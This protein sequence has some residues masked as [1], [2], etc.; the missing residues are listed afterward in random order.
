R[1]L[2]VLADGVEFV[3]AWYGALKAGG[4]TAEAYTFLPVKDLAYLLRYSQARLVVADAATLP[5]VREAVAASP[6]Q[7]TVIAVGV[8]TAELGVGELAWEASL[9]E[10]PE[11][12]PPVPTR[13][14]E[15]AIWKFTTG[16]T[17]S[18]KAAVHTHAAPRL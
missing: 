15:I 12:L 11:G 18:P 8:A 13:R 3:A 7:H 6:W 16:S 9:A 4:V 17:G 10:A 1:V 14:D 2:L 5:R